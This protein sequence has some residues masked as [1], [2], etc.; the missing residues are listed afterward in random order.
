MSSGTELYTTYQGETRSRRN[1]SF[2]DWLFDLIFNATYQKPTT[3][4]PG[5]GKVYSFDYEP[6]VSMVAEDPAPYGAK[7][8]N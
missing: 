3:P 5:T 2:R 6:P 1:Q 7:K 4:K 8:E